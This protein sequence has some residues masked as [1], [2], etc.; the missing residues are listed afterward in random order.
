MSEPIAD[1]PMI[2]VKLR[3]AVFK[4]AHRHNLADCDCATPAGYF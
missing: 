4:S 3:P 1:G 2:A